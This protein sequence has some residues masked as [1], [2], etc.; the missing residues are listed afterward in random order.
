[1]NARTRLMLKQLLNSPPLHHIS[2]AR[3]G[4]EMSNQ[5]LEDCTV[6]FKPCGCVTLMCVT[7]YI[8]KDT[9]REIGELVAEGCTVKHLTADETRKQPF[10]CDHNQKQHDLFAA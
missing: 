10:G 4:R 1:M 2:R 5:D 7:A 9:K 8:T 6:V 3:K